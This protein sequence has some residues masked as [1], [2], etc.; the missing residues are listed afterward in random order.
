[1]FKYLGGFFLLLLAVM[2]RCYS[3]VANTH[4]IHQ[5]DRRNH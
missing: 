1:M 2:L 4:Y 5:Y 3:V